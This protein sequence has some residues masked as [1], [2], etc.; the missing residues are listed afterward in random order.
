MPVYFII[1]LILHDVHEREKFISWLVRILMRQQISTNM[2][3]AADGADGLTDVCQL[4]DCLT[5]VS[6][7]TMFLDI[8]TKRI[9]FIVN[10]C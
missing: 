9:S 7:M 4:E 5:C 10:D 1:I 2:A 3:E 8:S 6:D